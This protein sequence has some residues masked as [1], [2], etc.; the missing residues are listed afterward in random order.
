VARPQD[1]WADFSAAVTSAMAS[2]LA[3]LVMGIGWAVVMAMVIVPSIADLT[4][5][6]DSLRTP[7]TS[8]QGKTTG[9]PSEGLVERYPDLGDVPENERGKIFVPKLISDQ[10]LGSAYGI[11]LSADFALMTYGAVVFWGT[12]A[13]GYLARRGDCFSRKV[14]P[15]LE[16]TVSL[17]VTCSAPFLLLTLGPSSIHSWLIWLWLA[18]V[19]TVVVLMVVQRAHW[20]LRLALAVTWVVTWSQVG[21]NLLPS[22]VPPVAYTTLAILLIR[23]CS[24][25]WRRQTLAAVPA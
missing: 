2:S 4:L 19:T 8:V 5:V 9:H 3:A 18:W 21:F 22:F 11:W 1:I 12:V 15:Y 13:A 20:M 25:R 7:G 23:H 16:L 6:G 24:L 14:V 17:T 10:I